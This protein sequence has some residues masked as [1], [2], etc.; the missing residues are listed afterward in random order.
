[1][2]DMDANERELKKINAKKQELQTQK[3]YL[4]YEKSRLIEEAE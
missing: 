4:I 1:M 3:E 2:L